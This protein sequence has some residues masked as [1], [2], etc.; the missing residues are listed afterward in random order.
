V[1]P[2]KAGISRSTFS[3][4]EFSKLFVAGTADVVVRGAVN[5]VRV[6]VTTSHRPAQR[7]RSFVKDLVSVIPGAIKLNRGKMT[8]RDLYYEAA[9]LGARRV[10]VVNSSKGNPSLID[11]YE[12]LDP[13]EMRLSRIVRMVLHGVRLSR[14]V[15]GSQR[16]FRVSSIGVMVSG[17]ASEALY[18]VADTLAEAFMARIVPSSG[19]AQQLPTVVARVS[20]CD[21]PNCVAFIEFVCTRSG[22]VC[23]PAFWVR[24]VV[25]YVQGVRL[26]KDRWSAA[27]RLEKRTGLA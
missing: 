1:A 20:Q 16:V 22:R 11:V 9:G 10:V 5:E 18:F 19:R 4:V 8:L 23:G 2:S 26:Y 14:E 3:D 24:S 6:I 27:A 21:R 25:N 7:T 15:Q 13:P 17:N 12:P